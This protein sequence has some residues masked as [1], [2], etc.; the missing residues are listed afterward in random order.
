MSDGT[1]VKYRAIT[2]LDGSVYF[3][4]IKEGESD[5][6]GASKK[7]DIKAGDNITPKQRLEA[8]DTDATITLDKTEGPDSVMNPKMKARLSTD[9]F[10]R[11][12][13]EQAKTKPSEG[14]RNEAFEDIKLL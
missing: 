8:I 12:Y 5:F 6:S 14:Q 4:A 1:K 9:Q 3:Q 7:L 10:N 11:V 2:R 13:P